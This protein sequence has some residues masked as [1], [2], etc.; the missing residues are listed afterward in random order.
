M[1]T[2]YCIGRNYAEHAAELNNAVPTEPVV[3]LK[4]EAALRGPQER[5]LAFATETFHHEAELVLKIARNA[6]LG[7]AG[8][9]DLVTEVALG[10]D[11]TRR[12]VQTELKA[13]G[14]P[15]TS[16]KSFAGAAVLTD[17][18]PVSSL[19]RRDAVEFTL[20]VNGELR[21][22]GNTKD[23]IFGVAAILTHLL[24]SQ[25]LAAGDLV[26]TGT[27]K[28]VGP[29]RQGDAFELAFAEP[30]RVFPGVL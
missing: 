12:G 18:I 20:T 7:S 15:W 25:A 3:F 28:G 22:Q 23:M 1:T 24:R 14:L 27:P 17:F 9:W 19:A 2:I 5:R 30:R 29:L 16:A 26:Y 11:L 13:K 6:P 21:Q 10:L 4:S 8:D